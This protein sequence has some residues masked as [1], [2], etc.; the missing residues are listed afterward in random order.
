MKM[1]YVWDEFDKE[2]L[3]RCNQRNAEWEYKSL[4]EVALN[5]PSEFPNFSHEESAYRT[6]IDL[7]MFRD[8]KTQWALIEACKGDAL[9][10]DKVSKLYKKLAELEAQFRSWGATK[11]DLLEF[12]HTTMNLMVLYHDNKTDEILEELERIEGLQY[13]KGNR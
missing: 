9:L 7:G 3:E 4:K 8:L 5:H 6:L 2:E 13:V 12:H 1:V 11:D 10:L